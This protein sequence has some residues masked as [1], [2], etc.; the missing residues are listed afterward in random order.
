MHRH[1][2]RSLPD[3][4]PG[5]GTGG[6][7]YAR[8]VE[9]AELRDVAL[10]AA[11][12]G[13][14]TVMAW[15][16][17]G[18]PLS[19]EKKGFG[20]YVTAVDRAAEARILEVLQRRTPDI[21]VL[22]EESGGDR[23]SRMWVVDP[24]DGTTN[25]LRGFLPAV[26][27]SVGLLEDGEPVAGAVVA[28]YTGDAWVAAAGCGAHDGRGRRLSVRAPAGRGIA[29]TGLPFRRPENRARYLPVMLA[30]VEAFEDLRRVGSA[31]L[32]CANVAGGVW[33]GYFELG[34]SLWD[35]AAGALLVREAGGRATDWDGDPVA[36]FE[37]GNIVCGA[38]GW[39][40]QMLD[41]I[42]LHGS[43]PL[44]AEASSSERPA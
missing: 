6:C 41:L 43:A 36:V 16:E 1:R 27:V 25:F 4:R 15:V 38:P 3:L 39:H 17:R 31:S 11:R 29:T 8:P 44:A 2:R 42:R 23:S 5:P 13:A 30:A 32:D 20:D 22:A 10:E 19:T 34:L 14:E 12:A 40:E 33:D 37:T 9:R 7:R 35:I 21:S 26:G 18:D 24:V 28:P